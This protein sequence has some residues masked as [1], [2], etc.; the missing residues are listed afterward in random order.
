LDAVFCGEQSVDG[1]L[2][3]FDLDGYKLYN[4]SFGHGAGDALLARLGHSLRVAVGD[5]GHA[6]RMGGDEFCIVA[7]AGGGEVGALVA[8]CAFALTERGDGF[9]VGCS[10]GSILLPREA[11]TSQAALSIVDAR[12]YLDKAGGRA[13]AGSQSKDVLRQAVSERHPDLGRHISSVA[14]LAD[15][16]ARQLGLDRG[17]VDEVR[18]AAE[19]H[20][21]GKVAI[22][23]DILMKQGPLDAAEWEFMRR[24]TIIGERIVGAAPALA[25]VAKIVRSSHE[26]IDGAG[27]PDG[28]SGHEIPLGARIL[29]PSDA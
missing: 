1:V 11:A 24:H 3:L 13:S 2:A 4:D 18:I 28:Q 21:V 23:D 5:R 20:D 8:E 22:P 12:M 10:F 14:T 7:G 6:Y 17:Q 27:Y 16:V 25:G 29:Y 19:L 15:A 26:R 9:A